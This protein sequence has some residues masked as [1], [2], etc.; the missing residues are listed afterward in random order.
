VDESLAGQRRRG[1]LLWHRNFRLL[2]FGETANQLG[3]AMAVVG[4]PLLAVIDLHASAFAVS[5]LVA[6]GWLPWL[7]IGL[8]AGA[9]VDRLPS[10]PVMI[11]CDVVSA[12][13]YSSVP[14]AYWLHGLTIAELLVVELLAGGAG[15]FFSTAYQVNLPS[16]VSNADLV[17]GNAKLQ[18]S[19]SAAS[20][21]GRGLAGLIAQVLGA[22]T[23]VLLNAISYLISAACLLAIRSSE[24]VTKPPRPPFRLRRDIGEGIRLVLRDPYLRQISLFGGLANFA[25]DGYAAIIV[26]FLVRVVGLS[27]GYVGFLIAVPGVGGLV[28]ALLAR[29]IAAQLGTARTILIST[30]C[31]LPFALLTPLATSGP[32]VAFYVVGV[33]VAATGIG[34]SNVIQVTF[35]QTYCR[36]EI[37]GRVTATMRFVTFGT[38]P[39]GALA[40]GGLA[41]W[42]GSRDA[43]WIILAILALSGTVLLTPQFLGRRDLPKASTLVA[44]LPQR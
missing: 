41:T 13:L 44:A 30:L 9:W 7:V 26:V 37:L 8:P 12:A 43:L 34:V 33:L 14:L 35:R 10:R 15:V 22:A 19:A 27:A 40:G 39:L 4:V 28:G 11:I 29:R 23:A 17:E 42:L 5:A 21:G 36:P 2:W 18:G 38:S 32:R 24:S 1:G 31:A 6:A 3:S 16:L 25:L 20:L